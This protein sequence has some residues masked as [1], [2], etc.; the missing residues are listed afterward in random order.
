MALFQV[1]VQPT[2][3]DASWSRYVRYGIGCG[4]AS[5]AVLACIPIVFGSPLAQVHIEWRDI[6]ESDRVLLEQRFALTEATRLEGSRWSYVPTDVSPDRLLAIVN[7]AA[8]ADTNG[9]NRRTFTISDTPPLTSRRGGLLEPPPWIASATRG[10]AYLLALVAVVFSARA[11]LASP[12]LKEGSPI[13]RSI[14]A[15]VKA[16][17]RPSS[18]LLATCSET[19]RRLTWSL[20]IAATVALC[21]TL[22]WRFMTFT[23]FTNDHFV[24][25]ALAQQLLL[26]DRPVR[27]FADQGWP[28]M[29]LLSAATW[30][31]A[32]DALVTEW[33]IAAAGFALGA[34]YT[35]A[36]GYRLSGS[37]VVALLVTI[38]E[39]LIYPRTYS[40][41]KVLV[42]AVASWAMVALA[43]RPSRRRIAIMAAVIAV[44]FLFRH[45]HGLFV[46][47][48][49][50]ACLALASRAS[51]WWIFLRRTGALTAYTIA[52][53]LPWIVFIALNGGLVEY[54]L[55]GLEYSR[56]EAVATALAAFPRLDRNPPYSTIPNAEA[57][58]FWLFWSLPVVCSVVLC[59]RVARRLERWSGE[60]AAVA[61]LVVLATLVNASFLRQSLQVRLPDAVVPAAAL[62]AW[63][64]GLCWVGRWR[65]RTFQVA[66]Q[67]TTVLAL[68]ISMGAISRIADLPGLY[69]ETDIGRGPARAAEHAREVSQL[70]GTRHRENRAP[71]SRV[72]RALMP[73]MSYL[74]RCTSVSDRLMVT[75]EFPEVLVIAGRAFAG[76]GVVFGSWYASVMQQERTVRQLHARPPLF[77]LHAGDYDGFRGRFGSV[78]AFVKGAYEPIAEVPV[79]GTSSVRILVHGDRVATG[80]D[81]ETGWSC[82]R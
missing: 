43:L 59:V 48:A 44:A 62:G 40:Y 12:V 61:G 23:G 63:A 18:M 68:T 33:A 9:I 76:D 54:F 36:A 60:S 73:F 42:Y 4:L 24:H 51:G 29:Y 67:F 45:D 11:A 27:D 64:L 41:P 14:D 52:L 56:A 74:D 32:G 81:P 35:V 53:L 75:G 78:D 65:V 49:S 5:G 82:Y 13:R 71:P 66:V 47:V 2:R 25:L 77:V 1:N 28:L 50:V 69:D 46:G 72:S 30:R 15:G 55:G 31:L 38:F 16:V 20:V 70:L 10:F 34:A 8:V 57:W 79:E 21:G 22:T 58:L 19:A 26:G 39:V 80:T 6:S 3:K 17:A 37:I 7:H